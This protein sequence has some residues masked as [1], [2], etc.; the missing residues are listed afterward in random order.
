[1][2][3][4][5]MKTSVLIGSLQSLVLLLALTSVGHADVV[6][7]NK[8]KMAL[9]F[10]FARYSEWPEST[11]Q[12]VMHFCVLGDKA[13]LA[14][15]EKLSGRKIKQRVIEVHEVGAEGSMGDC[16]LLVLGG[17]DRKRI[18]LALAAVKNEP[19]LTVGELPDFIDGGGMINLYREN[20]RVRFEI[21][22]YEAQRSGL[23]ISARL[24]Q[25][26]KIVGE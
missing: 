9:I 13:L 3:G 5:L 22:P 1:M 25:L 4:L 14:E 6:A 8:F 12:Q 7:E 2:V 10:N 24:L 19:T 16:E 20:G 26:A 15:L 17:K 23:L 18:A 21:N 11:S